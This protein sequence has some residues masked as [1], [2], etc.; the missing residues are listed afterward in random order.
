M[1]I[2]IVGSG[3]TG[4]SFARLLRD[5]GH[6]ILLIERNNHIGGL[7]YT[8][9]SPNGIFY[10]PYGARTFHTKI[11]KVKDFIQK[12]SDF[13]SYVHN[14]GMIINGKL[15]HFPVSL[16]T[17]KKLD[18]YPKIIKELNDR[19][20]KLD[21]K[22]F[23]TCMISIMGPT[24]Y[25]LFIKN[26]TEKMWG[27]SA[28]QLTAEWAPKRLEIREKDSALFK[29]QWQGLPKYGYTKLFENMVKGINLELKREFGLEYRK[30]FD[31]ILF[32]GR[33]DELL[34]FKYG[35]LP[36]R[37]L[38]FDYKKNENWEKDDYGTINLPQD[39]KYIRKANFKIM[40]QQKTDQNWIQ[41]QEPIPSSKKNIPMYP[42][43]TNKSVELFDN[44]L[45]D[46]CNSENIIPAG[47]LGLFKYLD[48]DKAIS[49]AFDMVPLIKIWKKIPP[50]TR[51]L[52]IKKI[53]ENY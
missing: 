25:H 23:E 13:N 38:R 41:Y 5:E 51:Y 44:Y 22:N 49:L 52:K 37:S 10:E 24:L 20:E 40:Y 2:L 46:A 15:L 39:K 11:G 32:T 33:I 28:N 18:E 42:V 27:T 8:K 35:K 29:N 17:I 26:Y 7:S 43:N 19:P 50:S 36:Y 48:M 45:K 9:L 3:F 12:F 21:R 14:K 31:L 34:H 16:E 47:R 30:G 1:K 6:Q 4:C 53:L